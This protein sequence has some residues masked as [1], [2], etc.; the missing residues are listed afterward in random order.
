[1]ASTTLAQYRTRVAA[2]LGLDNSTDGDQGLIDSWLN[3]AYE[4]VLTKTHCK[5]RPAT[6][7]FTAGSAQYSLP[8]QILAIHEIYSTQDSDGHTLERTTLQELARYRQM[9][10]TASAPSLYYVV[11]GDLLELWPTPGEDEAMT[12]WYIPRP[13]ALSNSGDVPSDI[14][15]EWHKLLEWY[16]LAE[17]AEYDNHAPSSYGMQWR[18]LYEKG[19]RDLRASLKYRGGAR[20]ARAKWGQRSGRSGMSRD[21]GRDWA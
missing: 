1:M 3:E 13:T 7:A 9:D 20:P 14:P 2:K 19:L 17:G 8:T 10:S 4:E 15:A 11:D 21:P 12:L 16:A 5:V 18:A 6:M